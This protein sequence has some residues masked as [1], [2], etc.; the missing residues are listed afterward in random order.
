MRRLCCS[1]NILPADVTA[2][3]KIAGRL[4]SKMAPSQLAS[5][6]ASFK[7]LD[8]LFLMQLVFLYLI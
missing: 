1:I 7:A 3:L 2:T 6:L 5:S 8:S 4:P